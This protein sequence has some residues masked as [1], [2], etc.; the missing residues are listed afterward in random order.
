MPAYH[1]AIMA[2]LL[3]VRANAIRTNGLKEGRETKGMQGKLA[4]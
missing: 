2:D 4:V 1:K 3:C